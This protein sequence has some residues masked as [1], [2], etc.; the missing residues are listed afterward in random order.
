MDDRLKCCVPF[1]RRTTR[2][3][4]YGEWICGPHWRAVPRATRADLFAAKRDLRKVL[5]T[6]PLAREYWKLPPGSPDWLRAARAWWAH[7][8]AWKACK[9]LAVENAFGI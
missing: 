1:C 8:D 9:T 2:G 6:V 4:D 7:D 3:Q 5:L